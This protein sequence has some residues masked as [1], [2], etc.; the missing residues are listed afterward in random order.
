MSRCE[1]VVLPQLR[2]RGNDQKEARLNEVSRDEQAGDE[3]DRASYQTSNS[4]G[5]RKVR[6]WTGEYPNL[7]TA[8]R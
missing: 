2:P 5:G 7:P 3:P 1:E 4:V 6:R 8:S